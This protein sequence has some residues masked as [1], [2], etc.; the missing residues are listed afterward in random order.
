MFGGK[1]GL[2]APGAK[3]SLRTIPDGSSNTFLVAE[4][5]KPVAWTKPQDLEFDGETVPELGG[6]FDGRFYAVTG[7]GSVARFRANV[8]ARTLKLW[9]DPDDGTPLPEDLGVDKER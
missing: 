4:A 5:G 6:M 3:P 8:K 2:F 1:R 7:D 9:I